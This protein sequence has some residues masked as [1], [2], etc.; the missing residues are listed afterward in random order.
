MMWTEARCFMQVKPASSTEL[1]QSPI[2]VRRVRNSYINKFQLPRLCVV[3]DLS[4]NG[5]MVAVMATW[6][7]ERQEGAQV[8]PATCSLLCFGKK[9]VPQPGIRI[10][11][12][13]LGTTE[14]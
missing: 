4:S 14:S 12:F 2:P 10:I 6:L 9:V 13:F 1:A 5:R 7:S 11:Q 8:L 3:D